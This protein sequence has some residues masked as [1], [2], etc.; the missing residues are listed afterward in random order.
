[1]ALEL[2]ENEYYS[3]SYFHL[4]HHRVIKC[5]ISELQLRAGLKCTDSC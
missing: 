1:M 2:V 3:F 4:L 5:D